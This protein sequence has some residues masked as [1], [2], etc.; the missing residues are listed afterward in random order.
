MALALTQVGVPVRVFEA[1]G[2]LKQE[3]AAIGL[4]GN[5]WRALDAL[6]VGE[7]LRQGHLQLGRV[8]LCSSRGELLRAFS[9][10]ECDVGTQSSAGGRRMS[11]EFRGV[12]RATLLQALYDKLP[13]AERLVQF[14]TGVDAVLSAG[15]GPDGRVAVRLS[16]GSTVYGSALV[17]ADGVGSVV[18][19]HLG[20]AKPNYA[21]YVALRGVAE[22]PA[23]GSGTGPGG[24]PLDTIRQIWG[25][26]VRAGLYPVTPSSCYWFV[27][28]NASEQ[29]ALRPTPSPSERRRLAMA[30]VRGWGWDVE[31]AVAATPPEDISWSRVSDRWTAGSC[32][33]GRVTLAGDAAHPMTPNLGQGGCVALEDAVELGRAVRQ[34]SH[35][36]GGGGALA[37]ALRSYE[38]G[39]SRR[40]LP[41]TVRSHLM[42]AALQIPLQ[43][44]CAVRNAFVRTAFQPSHFLDHTAYDCGTLEG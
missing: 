5:A 24:L 3:G 35:G 43:P 28:Y 10:S 8:E 32:G 33:S 11:T 38:A 36:G 19:R 2:G 15:D 1:G 16:D 20:L 12:R 14:G 44:V 39:R 27:C 23:Q 42:G 7:D 17:G 13:D 18:A 31:G 41:L 30:A 22:F 37:A 40:C 21:G 29:E 4:W 25:E 26:G 6:G 9:F 34:G